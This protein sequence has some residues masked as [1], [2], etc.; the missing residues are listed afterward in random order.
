MQIWPLRVGPSWIGIRTI[1]TLKALKLSRDSDS[2][3]IEN[4]TEIA[5]HPPGCGALIPTL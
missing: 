4:L 1:N 5:A 3:A 2:W